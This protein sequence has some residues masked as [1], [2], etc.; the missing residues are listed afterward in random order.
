MKQVKHFK[1]HQSPEEEYSCAVKLEQCQHAL[2]VVDLASYRGFHQPVRMAT[3]DGNH[4]EMSGQ[5]GA[6]TE[7]TMQLLFKV[8]TS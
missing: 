1:D 4:S 2:Q 7:Q 5:H 6:I 3:Q 8:N